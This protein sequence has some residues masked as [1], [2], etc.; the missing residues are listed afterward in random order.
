LVCSRGDATRVHADIGI[1]GNVDWIKA[2][3]VGVDAQKLMFG[4][5]VTIHEKVGNHWYIRSRDLEIV[6]VE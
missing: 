4:N 2:I 5:G 3:F 6:P 1:S